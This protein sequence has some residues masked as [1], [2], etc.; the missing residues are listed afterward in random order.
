MSIYS[1]DDLELPAT[2]NLRSHD[3]HSPAYSE[4]QS[5]TEQREVEPRDLNR[6]LKSPSITSDAQASLRQKQGYRAAEAYLRPSP[7]YVSGRLVS[8]V[9]DLKNCAFTMSLTAKAA[10]T[11]GAPTEIYLPEFHFPES[12]TVVAVSGG[13]WEIVCQEIQSIKIQCLRWWH[14]DGDHDIKI[15][16][17][18]RKL[19]ESALGD[20]ITY[21]EQC[22]QGQCAMM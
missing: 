12:S 5:S 16:G 13:K 18:K 15:E 10:T 6:A 9:F 14:A 11:P 7:I 1:H 20:D 8:H 19:G 22:Q 4:S 21:L 17:D 3:P 2:T